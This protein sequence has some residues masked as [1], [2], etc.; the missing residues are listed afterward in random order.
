[1]PSDVSAFRGFLQPLP[2]AVELETVAARLLVDRL[3][4]TLLVVRVACFGV[5]AAPSYGHR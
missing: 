2:P 5:F 4:A 3:W 1:M